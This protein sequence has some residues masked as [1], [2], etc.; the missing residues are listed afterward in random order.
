MGH[1]PREETFPEPHCNEAM[2]F[3]KFFTAVLRM[4][5]HPILSDILLK[6]QVQLHQLTPNAIVQL[7]KYIW[8]V[9]SFRGIPSVYGF[10]KRYELHYQ[11]REM[12]I[13]VAEVQGQYG[14][15]NFHAK[16]GGYGAKIIVIV[17]NKW[18]GAW[19]QA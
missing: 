15:L 12:E 4:P 17:K 13:D 5:P 19:T 7:L 9:T 8:A 6:F 16:H 3:E 2:V 1:E 14:C 18:A 10:A 11:P